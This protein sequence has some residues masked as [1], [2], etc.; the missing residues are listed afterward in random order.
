MT[1]HVPEQAVN[2]EIN[3]QGGAGGSGGSE[4]PTI[5]RNTGDVLGY[6]QKKNPVIVPFEQHEGRTVIRVQDLLM[7]VCNVSASDANQ[8]KRRLAKKNKELCGRLIATPKIGS[9]LQ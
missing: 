2:M 4:G 7:S 1:E 6:M 3:Q 8:I 5:I 9:E